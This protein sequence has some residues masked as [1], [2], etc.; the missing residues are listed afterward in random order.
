MAQLVISLVFLA[1]LMVATRSLVA[2]L[3]RPLL[4]RV[5]TDGYPARSADRA[6][7]P[8]TAR[9]HGTSGRGFMPPRAV[10]A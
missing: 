6:A 5:E 2:D 9:R 1:L 10:A 4:R 7:T 3:T 8:A